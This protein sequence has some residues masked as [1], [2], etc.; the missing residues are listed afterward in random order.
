MSQL[1]STHVLLT[2]DNENYKKH[3]QDYENSIRKL[4]SEF[5]R[6]QSIINDLKREKED[7][8]G[9]VFLFF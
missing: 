6:L 9:K 3:I 7:L 4:Y 5:E 1:Q 8:F 2:K